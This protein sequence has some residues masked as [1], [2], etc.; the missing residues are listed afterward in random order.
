MSL[1]RIFIT[2]RLPEK[3]LRPLSSICDLEVWSGSKPMTT[4]QLASAICE[5]DGIICLLTD[6][7]T[8]S[9]LKNL[10]RLKFISSMSVGVDHI[11]VIA[12][13]EKNIPVG[14]TPGVLAET[15]ADLTF[16]LLLAA[17]RRIP[18][19]DNFI[20]EGLWAPEMPWAPD[21]FLGKD[22]FGATLGIVGL[23]ETGKAVARRGKAF[24][25]RVLGWNRTRRE[26]A[27][28]ELVALDDLLAQS[29]FVSIHIALTSETLLFFD[30]ERIMSMK[31]GG[32]LINTARGGVVDENA[33]ANALR[34]GHLAAAG[35]DVFEREPIQNENALLDLDNVVFTPHVGS[36]TS[37]T[38]ERMAELAVENAIAAI[39]GK[40]M[41]NCVNPEVYFSR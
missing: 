30:C 35:I 12:A 1:N 16:G 17:A 24:G 29:D 9:V 31:K 4:S 22:V 40:P 41:P 2:Y 8:R 39:N 3:I 38:R 21:F 25:M 37:S 33:L 5:R 10:E 36:A 20:R 13:T 7:I 15:T 32:I 28:V 6:Q 34:N 27:D 18:E 26:V 23:G 11:D 19:A 14:N